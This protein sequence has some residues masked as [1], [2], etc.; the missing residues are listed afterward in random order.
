M[1]YHNLKM[2]DL[3]RIK[4]NRNIKI[5]YS[6]K[7]VDL[8]RLIRNDNDIKGLSDLQQR[9][10][11]D[12]MIRED[13]ER[14]IRISESRERFYRKIYENMKDIPESS[15]S[16]MMREKRERERSKFWQEEFK[17]IDEQIM[18]EREFYRAFREAGWT[19]ERLGGRR[20]FS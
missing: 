20:G 4:N 2:K 3:H 10:E 5:N 1:N 16:K 15:T 19:V 8:I 17:R 13:K 11:Y 12:K 6:I 18:E 7:K 9:E 14:D